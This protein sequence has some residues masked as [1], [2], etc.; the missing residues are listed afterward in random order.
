MAYLFFWNEK[1][2][3]I[4]KKVFQSIVFSWVLVS[5]QDNAQ[6]QPPLPLT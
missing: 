5:A 1:E 6:T 3:W 4:S 2:T